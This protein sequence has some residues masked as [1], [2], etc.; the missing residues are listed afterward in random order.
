MIQVDENCFANST[1]YSSFDVR[2]TTI[3]GVRKFAI[4]HWVAMRCFRTATVAICGFILNFA[5]GPL[6]YG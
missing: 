4:L 3:L 1:R 2:K 6:V 5:Y